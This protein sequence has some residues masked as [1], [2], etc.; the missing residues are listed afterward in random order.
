M[1]DASEEMRSATSDLRRQDAAQAAAAGN[2]ALQRLREAQR[3]LEV[4]APDERRRAVGDLQLEARQLADAQRQVASE[5][6]DQLFTGALPIGAHHPFASSGQLA[7]VQPGL[8]FVDAFANSAAVDTTD[9]LQN[10]WITERFRAV[11]SPTTP[12]P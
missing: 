7:E 6:A 8:A 2:R 5:L 4:A 12:H 10:Q 11:F 3:N 1:R 9:G